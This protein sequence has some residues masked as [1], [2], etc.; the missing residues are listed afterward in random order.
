MLKQLA[1]GLAVLELARDTL[2]AQARDAINS[3]R[4]WEHEIAQYERAVAAIETADLGRAL[5]DGFEVL[6]REPGAEQRGCSIAA[7]A[8]LADATR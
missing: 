8:L 3:P 4:L 5:S 6:G 2:T 1:T 7:D